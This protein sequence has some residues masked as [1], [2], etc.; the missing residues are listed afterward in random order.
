VQE[1]PPETDL[2]SVRLKFSVDGA[3]QSEFPVLR[4]GENQRIPA[5]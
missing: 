1:H 2:S 5:G 3:G 4:F